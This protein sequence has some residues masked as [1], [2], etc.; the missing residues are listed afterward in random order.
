M[1]DDDSFEILIRS[2]KKF[3]TICELSIKTKNSNLR[4][5]LLSRTIYER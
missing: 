2:S 4:A 5:E 1:D 3:A